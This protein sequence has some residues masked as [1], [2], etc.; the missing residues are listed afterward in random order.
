MLLLMMVVACL[1]LTTLAQAADLPPSVVLYRQIAHDR[2][3]LLPIY[4][5][6]GQPLQG[7]SRCKLAARCTPGA[8]P[9]LA[10][11]TD[12]LAPGEVDDCPDVVLAYNGDCRTGMLHRTPHR[13]VS[14][15]PLVS[16]DQVGD[17]LLLWFDNVTKSGL[18][19]PTGYDAT[20]VH[21]LESLRTAPPIWGSGVPPKETPLLPSDWLDVL[22][23]KPP[24]P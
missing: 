8:R 12:L 4:T 22:P 14:M 9:F 20:A 1:S 17:I 10:L 6:Q 15:G 3:D 2:P 5:V 7:L 13:A 18:E 16:C 11:T 24:Q 19:A 21:W 23:V